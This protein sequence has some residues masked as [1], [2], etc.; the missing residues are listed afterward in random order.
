MTMET[1]DVSIN[2]RLVKTGN[3]TQLG[4]KY[5]GVGPDDMLALLTTAAEHLLIALAGN[6]P[7]LAG[8]VRSVVLTP[9]AK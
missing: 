9:G 4:Q 6:T 5:S 1:Y 8:E 2:L 3:L 7:K